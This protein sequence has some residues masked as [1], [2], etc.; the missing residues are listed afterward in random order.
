MKQLVVLISVLWAISGSAAVSFDFECGKYQYRPA[1]YE[2]MIVNTLIKGEMTLKDDIYTLKNWEGYYHLVDTDSSVNTPYTWAF[3][4][5]RGDEL[6]PVANYRPRKYKDHLKLEIPFSDFGMSFGETDLI[7]PKFELI[8][9]KENVP[10]YLVMTAIE[11]HFGATV[12]L[13]CRIGYISGLRSESNLLP[14]T[15]TS[16][17]DE[18]IKQ[19]VEACQALFQPGPLL[20]SC[21]ID[22]YRR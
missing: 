12:P 1:D 14:L 4:S 17:P 5:G 10:A 16:D 6:S 18:Q 19:C 11:D 3:A 2:W 15:I 22:C 21:V 7:F 13:D 9:G 20:K 8:K